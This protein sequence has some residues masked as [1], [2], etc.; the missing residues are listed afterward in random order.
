MITLF[1]GRPVNIDG[2]KPETSRLLKLLSTKWRRMLARFPPNYDDPTRQV[3][4]VFERVFLSAGRHD[5]H[6]RPRRRCV[7]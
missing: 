6:D 4:R 2:S 1:D 3:E 7:G 5:G